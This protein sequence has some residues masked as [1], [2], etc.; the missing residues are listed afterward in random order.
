MLSKEN[1][2]LPC[3]SSLKLP[4]SDVNTNDPGLIWSPNRL[5]GIDITPIISSEAVGKYLDWVSVF[6]R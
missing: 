6:W 5:W 4:D 3:P 1:I 2:K